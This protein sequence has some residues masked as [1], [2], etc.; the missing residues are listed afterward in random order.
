MVFS[1]GT[2]Y[3]LTSG[4]DGGNPFA[5]YYTKYL[6]VFCLTQPLILEFIQISVQI[7]KHSSISIS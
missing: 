1:T 7:C 4:S 2:A 3:Q 5:N 6:Q